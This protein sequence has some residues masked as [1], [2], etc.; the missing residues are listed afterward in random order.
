M[1]HLH[2]FGVGL[3]DRLLLPRASI[4]E[5]NIPFLLLSL[6]LPTTLRKDIE[7]LLRPHTPA[8]RTQ[9]DPVSQA[10]TPLVWRTKR[11][12]Y[13]YRPKQALVPFSR[14]YP[15]TPPSECPCL[16]Q[17]RFSSQSS[18]SRSYWALPVRSLPPSLPR[19]AS[20]PRVS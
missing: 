6:T 19:S 1:I 16:A 3:G 17:P 5:G 10:R 8:S 15:S 12:A 14:R 4:S 18:A 13:P 2:Q 11:G 7:Q 9:S 20:S